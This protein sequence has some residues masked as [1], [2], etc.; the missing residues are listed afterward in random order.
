CI[1][2]RQCATLAAVVPN[3]FARSRKTLALGHHLVLL[4]AIAILPL[5]AFAAWIIRD[6][7]REQQRR[8]EY[9]LRTTAR[10]L[11]IAV[12]REILATQRTLEI[13]AASE[14][15]RHDELRAFH[16]EAQR[17]TRINDMWYVVAL[18]DARGQMLLS[19][20]RVFGTP[21]PDL[22]DRDYIRQIIGSG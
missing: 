3:W 10:A 16:A 21:L 4:V 13:L 5:L 9:G 1:A 8:V 11:A 7:G 6:V 17:M 14:L 20:L 22:G 18:T 19:S 15:L 12:E 2:E